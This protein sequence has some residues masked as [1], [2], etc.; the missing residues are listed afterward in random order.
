MQEAYIQGES[1]KFAVPDGGYT[2]AALRVG[3]GEAV[4]MTLADGVWSAS[5]P[6]GDL[7]G[8][9]RYAVFAT[10]DGALKAVE[11]GAFLVTPLRSKY[12]DV[13]EAIDAALQGVAANGKYSIT[14]GEISLTDKTFDEMIKFEEYYRGLAEQDETGTTSIGRV[15]TIQARF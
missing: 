2:S 13:V 7:S 6:S 4:A 10:I 8:L 12:W 5:V 3:G 11:S 15:G 1:I 9:V 14:V